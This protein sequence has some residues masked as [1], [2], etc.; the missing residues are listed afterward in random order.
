MFLFEELRDDGWEDEEEE[1]E[2][3][4]EEGA[5]QHNRR[6]PTDTRRV[7]IALF[8]ALKINTAKQLCPF[9]TSAQF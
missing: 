9:N 4:E 3:E 7:E 5:E 2:E 6:S 1:E 8:F